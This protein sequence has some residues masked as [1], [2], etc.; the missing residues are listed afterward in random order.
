MAAGLIIEDK[1]K[2]MV[3]F[4]F[5]VWAKVESISGAAVRHLLCDSVLVE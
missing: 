1:S 4:G 3:V 5:A 2:H